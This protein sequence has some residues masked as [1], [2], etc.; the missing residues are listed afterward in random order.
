MPL[1]LLLKMTVLL[2]ASPAVI[3]GAPVPAALVVTQ[4]AS[5]AIDVIKDAAGAAALVV[6][7]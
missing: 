2:L 3:E 4:D 5:A 6:I 7:R 1:L